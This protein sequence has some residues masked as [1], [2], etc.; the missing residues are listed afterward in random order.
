MSLGSLTVLRL[1]LCLL[2]IFAYVSIILYYMCMHV[3]WWCKLVYV[4]LLYFSVNCVFYVFLQYCDTV[5]WVFWPVKT[6]ACLTYTV[7]VET[8]NHAQSINQCELVRSRPVWMSNHPSSVLWHCWLGHQ[9]CRNVVPEMTK[10]VEWVLNLSQPTSSLLPAESDGNNFSESR[11]VEQIAVVC[12]CSCAKESLSVVGKHCLNFWYDPCSE[13]QVYCYFSE[14]SRLML[15]N[16]VIYCTIQC[17]VW[18][19]DN[20][21][22]YEYSVV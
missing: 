17:L 14:V 12:C 9:T 4:C 21:I 13:S 20:G 7:L 1:C 6:V 5:G 2:D 18:A 19:C 16:W 15:M 8:L 11:A 22:V 10:C 3:I